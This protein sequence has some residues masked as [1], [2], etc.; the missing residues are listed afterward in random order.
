MLPWL[1]CKLGF[2]KVK[3]H[4]SII[5]LH[6]ITGQPVI[7]QCIHCGKYGFVGIGE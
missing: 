5:F 4:P 1:K 6:E 7:G 2:H 3:I